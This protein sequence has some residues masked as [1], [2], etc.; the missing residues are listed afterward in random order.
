MFLDVL[1][2]SNVVSEVWWYFDVM[3]C[4]G[5]SW[6]RQIWIVSVFPV[7]IPGTGVIYIAPRGILGI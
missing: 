1:T 5:I 4:R 2:I 6:R 7:D 3:F